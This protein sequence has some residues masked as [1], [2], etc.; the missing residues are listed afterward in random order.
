MAKEGIWR[1]VN[2]K[3]EVL[4]GEDLLTAALR[5]LEEETGIKPA[6]EFIGLGQIK[7]P[8]EKILDL[9]KRRHTDLIVM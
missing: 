5:E 2:S 8:S 9:S 7:Q 3:G 1:L 4:A 6:G